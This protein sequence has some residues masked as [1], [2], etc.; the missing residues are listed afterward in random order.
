M[1]DALITETQLDSNHQVKSPNATDPTGHNFPH[2]NGIIVGDDPSADSPA[3]PSSTVT[4]I[5]TPSQGEMLSV[6]VETQKLDSLSAV[7]SGDS[8]DQGISYCIGTRFTSSMSPLVAPISQPNHLPSPP[9]DNGVVDVHM[10]ES[11]EPNIVDGGENSPM[12]ALKIHSPPNM[13]VDEGENDSSVIRMHLISIR[14][15]Q[16]LP[17]ACSVPMT[18]LPI[19]LRRSGF[20]NIPMQ[21]KHPSHM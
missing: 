19:L 7:R 2:S 8:T 18:K 21:N 10:S 9:L 13:D 6:E 14:T 3:T 5:R 1:S 17:M 15:R 12:G 16:H 20:G 4:H 11:S